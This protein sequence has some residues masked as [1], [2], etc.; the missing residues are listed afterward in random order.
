MKVLLLSSRQDLVDRGIMDGWRGSLLANL[1]KLI[2]K[3]TG[4]PVKL[5]TILFLRST[6][7]V[8]WLKKLF[9]PGRVDAIM[10]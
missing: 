8:K 7:L 3:E 6:E 4:L 10:I 2:S 9:I 5:R 1:D